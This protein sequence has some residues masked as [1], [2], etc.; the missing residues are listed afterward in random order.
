MIMHRV[1]LPQLLAAKERKE[2]QRRE[3]E[4]PVEPKHLFVASIHSRA[5]RKAFMVGFDGSLTLPVFRF[6]GPI[7]T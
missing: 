1:L 3:G 7:L 4:T 6:D 2:G 5:G